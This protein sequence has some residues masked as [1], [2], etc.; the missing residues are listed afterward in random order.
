MASRDEALNDLFEMDSGEITTSENNDLAKG[1]EGNQNSVKLTTVETTMALIAT[2]IGIPVL[3]MPY[4][5]QHLGQGLAFFALLL[6]GAVCML[7][8]WLYLVTKD[9]T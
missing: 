6:I 9:L 4:A 1:K 7:S 8:T 5:F 2:Y 3:A